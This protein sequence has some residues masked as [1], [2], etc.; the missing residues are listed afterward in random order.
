M[1]RA[2]ATGEWSGLGT[3]CYELLGARG[4]APNVDV[5][6]IVHAM[7]DHVLSAM[8]NAHL[9]PPVSCLVYLGLSILFINHVGMGEHSQS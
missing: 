2:E 6:G 1:V 8:H 7:H 5:H 4:H 9:I 3:R